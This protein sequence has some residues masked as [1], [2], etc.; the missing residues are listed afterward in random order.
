MSTNSIF[1]IAAIGIATEDNDGNFLDASYTDIYPEVLKEHAFF[2]FL[3][4]EKFDGQ[5]AIVIDGKVFKELHHNKNYDSELASNKKYIAIYIKSDEAIETTECA[6][7]KL[8]LLSKLISKPNSLNLEGIFSA[9]PNNAWTNQ[10]PIK[11]SEINERLTSS[12]GTNNPLIV[13]SV[14]K[15]PKMTDYVVPN[16]V[17][18]ADASRVRLG[19]HLA[20]GTTIMHEGFVNFN[21]GTLGPCMI[22]GRIS[23]GVTID[24][25]SDIG[26]GAS[27]MGTLSGGNNIKI[28]LGKR[29]LIGANAGLG[30]PLGDDCTVEAG[31]Y[32]TA[33]TKVNLMLNSGEKVVKASELAGSD[34]LLFR[35]N[36]IS[37]SVEAIQNKKSIELNQELHK[38]S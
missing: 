3:N 6:Y 37:G 15:F 34:N 22:E 27:T 38:N 18:I 21:A 25:H 20:P 26:G 33:G 28:S 11:A 13:F 35:R 8:H 7:L 29:S 5:K 2:S 4:E 19:A 31:L 24:A 1:P 17:R 36:S 16:D 32:L 30:I 9:L 14:D 10:G 12:I 23:A